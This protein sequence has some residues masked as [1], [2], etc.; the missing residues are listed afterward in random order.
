MY[1]IYL[2]DVFFLQTKLFEMWNKWSDDVVSDTRIIL[3]WKWKELQI[4]IYLQKHKRLTYFKHQKLLT[5]DA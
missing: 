2:L 4:A 1:A 3:K 5:F